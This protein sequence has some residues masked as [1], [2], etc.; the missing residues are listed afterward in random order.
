[1]TLRWFVLMLLVAVWLWIWRRTHG[2]L[3]QDDCVSESWVREHRYPRD[4]RDHR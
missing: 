2:P 1:M 3:I 4:G